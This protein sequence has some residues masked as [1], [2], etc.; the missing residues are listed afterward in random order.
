MSK[1]FQELR[2]ELGDKVPE[3]KTELAGIVLDQINDLT[4][5][6]RPVEVKVFGPDAATLRGLALTVSKLVEEAG[7]KDVNANVQLGNPDL[8]VLPKCEAIA[9]M[10]LNESDVDTQLDVALHGQVAATLPQQDR[11][12]DI[13]VRYPDAVRFDRN[14]LA[15]LPI[16]RACRGGRKER[17]GRDTAGLR[18][19]QPTGHDRAPIHAERNL[20]REPA[21][22]D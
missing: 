15:Q 5:V 6:V 17:A 7:A 2:K 3:A 10:G 18:H 14:R 20:A 21:A 13:R 8:F 4:G 1:I 9:R 12:T 11:I 16:A 19:A 22:D